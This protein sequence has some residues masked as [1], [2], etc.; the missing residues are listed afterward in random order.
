M[1]RHERIAAT[2]S[3]RSDRPLSYESILQFAQKIGRST[4]PLVRDRLAYLYS[5]DRSGT[6]LSQRMRQ[7]VDAGHEL[8]ARGSIAKLSTSAIAKQAIEVL[9]EVGGSD[10]IAWADQPDAGALYPRMTMGVVGAPARGI[11]GGS[12][13]IQRGIIGERVLGLAK[14]P[15]LDREIPFSELSKVA[16]PSTPTR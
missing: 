6:L 16:L 14:D 11:A 1:L 4:D 13:E 15:Q 9:D 2:T 12:N 3:T 10:V 7:E 5:I 8:R